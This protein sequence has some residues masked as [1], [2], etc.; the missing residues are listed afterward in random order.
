MYIKGVAHSDES[1]DNYHPN[2]EVHN[3]AL[4]VDSQQCFQMHQA[5]VPGE[6]P[7]V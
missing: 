3:F 4:F 1:T 7:A 2:L 6:K 5:A